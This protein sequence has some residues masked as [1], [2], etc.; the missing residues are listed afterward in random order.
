MEYHV[1]W[2]LKSSCFELFSDEKYGLF[3]IQKVDGKMIF[4]WIFELSIIFQNFGIMGFGAVL[5]VVIKILESGK[6]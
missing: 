2:V 4:T 1:Y 5:I 3:L 6:E